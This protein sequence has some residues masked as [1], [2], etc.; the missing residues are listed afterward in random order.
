MKLSHFA[1]MDFVIQVKPGK[2]VQMIVSSLQLVV[3]KLVVAGSF[4]AHLLH[5]LILQVK[6]KA[7]VVQVDAGK[8]LVLRSLDA[9]QYGYNLLVEVHAREVQVKQALALLYNRAQVL[10]Y[11]IGVLRPPLLLFLSFCAIFEG[12]AG[13]LAFLLHARDARRIHS[14]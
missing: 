4:D 7:V 3:K 6:V 14:V 11:L 5:D 8:S 10:H 2:I 1:V 13:Q 9:L 12:A